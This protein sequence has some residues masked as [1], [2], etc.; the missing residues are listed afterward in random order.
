[1]LNQ[2]GQLHKHDYEHCN[3]LLKAKVGLETVNR[4]RAVTVYR[5]LCEEK[6]LEFNENIDNILSAVAEK[7]YIFVHCLPNDGAV[8]YDYITTAAPN[9]EVLMRDATKKLKLSWA[10]KRMFDLEGTEITADNF[11]E[12]VTNAMSVVFSTGEDFLPRSTQVRHARF[13]KMRFDVDLLE[14]TA[15]QRNSDNPIVSE[16]YAHTRTPP[17]LR[18]QTEEASKLSVFDPDYRPPSKFSAKFSSPAKPYSPPVA[19]KFNAPPDV[20]EP[21][22]GLRSDEPPSSRVKAKLSVHR[23][24]ELDVNGAQGQSWQEETA[25]MSNILDHYHETL[26]KQRARTQ[27][28]QYIPPA[29]LRGKNLKLKK[30]TTALSSASTAT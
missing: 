25:A 11:S 27:L 19:T 15:E 10:A 30:P 23:Y 12:M 26:Y 16:G 20:D 14:M 9:P 6:K 8:D 28:D 1:V 17:F 24:E 4:T 3:N 13:G 5:V 7:Q 21:G 2:L 29:L 22:A 18:T